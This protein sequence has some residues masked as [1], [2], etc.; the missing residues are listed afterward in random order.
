MI[1]RAKVAPPNATHVHFYGANREVFDARD[2]ELLLSGP[3]GTGKSFTLLAK[4]FLAAEKYPGMRGLIVRKTRESLTEAG[5]VTWEDKVIPK[6]HPALRGASRRVRQSYQFPNGSQIVVGGLDKSQKIMSTEYD[7]IYVQ[8]AIELSENDWENLTTRLRNGRMP[9][10]QLIADTNPDRPTHWLKRRCDAGMTRLIESRHEDNPG[11]V[12]P[13]SG[14]L[15]PAG[16]TYLGKL[17]ALT[18]ARKQRLRYGRWVQSEGV[19]YEGYDPAVH[20]V[21][22]IKIPC[23]WRRFWAV[24]FGYTNAFV[25]L[26]GALD[27]DGRL[28]IYD[29][30]YRTKTLVQDHAKAL[31]R[32]A[33]A[34]DDRLNTYNWMRPQADRPEKIFCDHDAE[35]RAT[36][37]RHLGLKVYPADKAVSSGIQAVAAR[38]IRAGDGKPRLGIARNSRNHVADPDLLDAKKPARLTE[39]F[40]G[41][42]WHTKNDVPVKADDHALDALRYLVMGIDGKPAPVLSPESVAV[43]N[44]IHHQ[45]DQYPESESLFGGM[46]S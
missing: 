31:L 7:M 39:E 40:D 23:Q 18:G 27:P 16:N 2:G 17:D 43:D 11:I 15:T 5:L 36:L 3:A 6:G 30:I 26:L 45:H 28:I 1:D 33:G 13:H 24:D 10:Q 42:I 22:P 34:W 20:V 14:E 12:H 4:L 21:D 37:E 35:D 44:S 19:V 29:E 25:A 9:Y 41:Y 46:N 8:E 38:L 32:R